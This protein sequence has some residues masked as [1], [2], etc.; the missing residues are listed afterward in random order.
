MKTMTK[1]SAKNYQTSNE[2]LVDK[3]QS[4]DFLALDEL[5]SNNMQLIKF[6]ASKFTIHQSYID[7]DDLVQVGWTG[8]FRAVQ[9][10]RMDL[11]NSA[12][13]STWAV[14]WIRQAIQRYLE[15]RK[16]KTQEISLCEEIGEEITLEDSIEDPEALHNLYREIERKELQKELDEVMDDR[17]SLKERDILKLRYG[18][19]SEVRW[20][21]ADIA[22]L[23]GITGSGSKV[24]VESALFKIRRSP[25]GRQ[26]LKEHFI[27]KG[28]L[29]KDISYR[30][31]ILEKIYRLRGR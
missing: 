21:Y 7:F 8:F 20:S 25:W 11:K 31:V 10:Y 2:D 22:K 26:R 16:P 18:W 24:I 13:F 3:Y 1:K 12:K 5:T 27:E 28:L 30:T 9:T 4:G 23:Y 6:I 17:L 15:Q 29:I 14:Y 19:E